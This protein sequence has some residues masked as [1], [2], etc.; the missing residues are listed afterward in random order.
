MN[1]THLTFPEEPICT[2]CDYVTLIYMQYLQYSI[3]ILCL[4]IYHSKRVDFMGQR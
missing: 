4:H 3:V 2:L 1:V